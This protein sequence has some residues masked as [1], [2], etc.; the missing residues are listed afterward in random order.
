MTT[1]I[2]PTVGIGSRMNPFTTDLNKALLPYKNKPIL[3]HIIDQFPIDSRFIIPIGH[4]SQQIV[5]FCELAYADRD[6]EF[7]KI[8][9]WT[10]SQSG[11]GT[12]LKQCAN[13]ISGPFWYVPCDTYFN[14]TFTELHE[15]CYF[16][17]QLIDD[18][19]SRLYTMFDIDADSKIKDIS[20]KQQTNHEWYAFT[21][22][23]HIENHATFFDN[24]HSSNSNEFIAAIT[25][26]SKVRYLPTWLD[27]GNP[28]A[29][30]D[31]LANSQQFDFSKKNEITYICNDRVVKWWLDKETAEKKFKKTGVMHF[32]RVIWPD[33]CEYQNNWFAYDYFPGKTLYDH[34]DPNIFP[35]LLDWLDKWLWQE[36]PNI[37]TLFKVDCM[38]FYMTKTLNRVKLF[39]EKYPSLPKIRMVDG[40]P[41][42]EA[43][44]ERINWSALINNPRPGLFHGDLQFDNIIISDNK[45][46]KLIDWRPDFGENECFGDIYY[47]LAKLSGGFIIN[48]AMVKQGKIGLKI[49]GESVSLDIPHIPNMSVYQNELYTYMQGKK[50]NINKIKLLVPIIFLNMAP[51]HTAPFD[52]A[53][54]YL[55]LKLLH[56]ALLQPE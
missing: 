48:Y 18:E 34:N 38:N 5:D 7:V 37:E 35:G 43:D 41:I 47:D 55:G 1:V 54:W 30:K 16:V 27:F 39:K 17:H 13:L 32:N 20:F 44:I 36:N 28:E 51:L 50:Y 42:D 9:D 4:L 6:I 53:L 33:N 22:L 40:F 29:Y 12:T 46:I 14:Q 26:G 45:E 49:D 24:L 19:E 25:L 31:A 8:E 10:S 56:E 11:T 52:Q 15:D 21:G 3:A 23:M 2:I